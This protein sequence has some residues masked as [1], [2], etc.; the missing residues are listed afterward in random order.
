MPAEI[1]WK[2]IAVLDINH[3]GLSIAKQLNAHGKAV[4]AF[5]VYQKMPPEKR[6]AEAEKCGVSIMTSEDGLTEDFDIACLPIHL[7]PNNPFYKKAVAIGLPILTHH[8]MVGRLLQND[9]RLSGRTLIEVTGVRGKTSTAVLTAQMLSCKSPVLLHTS[10]GMTLWDGGRFEQIAPGVSITPACIPELIDTA[11]EKKGLPEILVFEVSLGFTGAQD[12]GILTDLEPAY[13]IAADTQT[14]TDAK[15]ERIGRSKDNNVLIANY[16]DLETV[17]PFLR[18]D[19]H[20]IV[21]D[22]SGAGIEEKMPTDVYLDITAGPDGGASA[23][24]ESS[25]AGIV[26]RAA[27]K[28][29]YD[30]NAYKRAMAAAVAAALESDVPETCIVETLSAFDGVKGRMREYREN[31]CLILDNSNSG[32]TITTAGAAVEYMLEKYRDKKPRSNSESRREITLVIGEEEKTVCEGLD[33]DGVEE[34]LRTYREHIQNVIVV[35]ERMKR[36][37]DASFAG[38]FREGLLQAFQISEEG[39]II[40]AVVKC[41]R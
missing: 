16:A 39:D 13:P 38:S 25:R 41:F 33:P 22:D 27:L 12:I 18:D 37:S 29:G 5:D 36:F 35:G 40:I 1:P 3:G 7:S 20:V 11:C 4:T 15:T 24:V 23:D 14:S 2:K 21:F 26:F 10:E 30:V 31:G 32:L 19:R 6:A 9:V 34:L 17:R 8:E 28:S